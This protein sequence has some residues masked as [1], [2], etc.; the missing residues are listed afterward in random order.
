MNLLHKE[1]NEF[2][3][4]YTKKI[5]EN[6]K[7]WTEK[8]KNKQQNERQKVLLIQ[9]QTDCLRQLQDWIDSDL[10]KEYVRVFV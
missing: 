1:S 10:L 9:I 8:T 2:Q 7:Y 6:T 3:K 5:D 4:Y